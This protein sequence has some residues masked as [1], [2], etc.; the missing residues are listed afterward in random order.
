MRSHS[1]RVLTVLAI[2]GLVGVVPAGTASARSEAGDRAE[3]R[4]VIRTL[5]DVE[6]PL[7][8]RL[9][10]IDDGSRLRGVLRTMSRPDAEVLG[11]PMRD[12]GLTAGSI[13]LYGDRAQVSF[14]PSGALP[15]TGISFRGLALRRDGR[16]VLSAR[17]FCDATELG[18]FDCPRGVGSP[19]QP[20][21]GRPVKV[22]DDAGASVVP[23]VFVEG[24][25]AEVV[26]PS[27]APTNGWEAHPQALL[28]MGE[29]RVHVWLGYGKAKPDQIATW[30]PGP[31]GSRVAVDVNLGLVVPMG[32][33]TATVLTEGLG[34]RVQRAIARG[35]T[36]HERNGF[37]VLEPA[38][39][40]SFF[41][42]G[43]AARFAKT[44]L[45]TD[46]AGLPIDL[47]RSD[48]NRSTTVSITLGECNPAW[49]RG[50]Q[51]VVQSGYFY[52]ERCIDGGILGVEGN[53]VATLQ[54]LW[55]GVQIR[56]VVVPQRA[57]ES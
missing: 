49:F 52:G 35:L 39:P 25:R 9:A 8:Q 32:D 26:L 13:Q 34:E 20:Y 29:E 38:G 46:P 4:R 28:R 40:L 36:G 23:V 10:L 50:T 18:G 11:V 21:A 53:D 42:V 45:S 47:V 6:V 5:G 1:I 2:V 56:E 12:I 16:W 57:A 7:A 30:Y 54:T 15:A 31:D 24:T 33:W 43:A 51:P 17:S 37:P 41:G 44:A 3:I 22:R 27:S 55:D 19:S 48:G 14:S